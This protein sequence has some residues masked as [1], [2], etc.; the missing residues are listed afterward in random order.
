M[1]NSAEISQYLHNSKVASFPDTTNYMKMYEIMHTWLESCGW[2]PSFGVF[3]TL[4]FSHTM[5][6]RQGILFLQD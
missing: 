5:Y 3:G 1:A 4:Y 2:D 6:L